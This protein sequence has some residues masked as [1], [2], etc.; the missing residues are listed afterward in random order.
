[1]ANNYL[2]FSTEISELT[3]K[4]TE[5]LKELLD[6]LSCVNECDISSEE[7]VNDFRDRYYNVEEALLILGE[8][9]TFDVSYSESDVNHTLWLYAEESGN[10][11]QAG[12]LIQE[13]LKKFRITQTHLLSWADTCSK[14][15]IDQ[16]GGGTMLIT[17]DF[18]Y[19][20]PDHMMMGEMANKYT[21]LKE[22][23]PTQVVEVHEC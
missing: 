9:E 15:R 4:E 11:Y 20:Q 18:I 3:V 22:D 21:K 7:S 17:A 10:I 5:W 19:M 16:F 23:D 1:M 6:T 8:E 14:M 13:F 2:Q 12:T